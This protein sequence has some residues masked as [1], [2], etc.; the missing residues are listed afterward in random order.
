MSQLHEIAS[1]MNQKIEQVNPSN[2]NGPKVRVFPQETTS[3]FLYH[4]NKGHIPPV[5]VYKTLYQTEQALKISNL[6]GDI[7]ILASLRDLLCEF[8]INY[9]STNQ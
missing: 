9:E 3:E 2:G 4:V 1:Y 7:K 8:A 6:D 5:E